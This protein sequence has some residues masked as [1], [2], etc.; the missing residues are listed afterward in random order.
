[1]MPASVA[2]SV[3]KRIG[4]KTSVGWAAPYE[5]RKARMVVGMMVKPEVFKTKNMIIGFVAVSFF[6]LS[7]CICCIAFSPV[8][9][10]ALSSPSM[11]EAMFMKILPITGWF[12]GMSGKS[13]VKTGLSAR[14][15]T[16]TTPAFSPIFMMPSQR[17]STPVSPREISKAFFEESK[18][19][20]T[21]FWKMVVSPIASPM[22]AKM[23]AITK[24]AIQI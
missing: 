20:S 13:F 7:S 19:E 10:A 3:A 18:V 12:F 24:K 9:V 5:A 11:L 2:T 6:G 21:I 14:A 22:S 17:A 15:N 1:M 16:F 8:G 23:N 4:M